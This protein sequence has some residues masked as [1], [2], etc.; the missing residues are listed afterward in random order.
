[1]NPRVLFILVLALLASAGG[2]WWL[3]QESTTHEVDENRV[4]AAKQDQQL[5]TVF[6]CKLDDVSELLIHRAERL[7][8][9]RLVPLGDGL[10]GLTDTIV[11]RASA[12]MLEQVARGLFATPVRPV[13]AAWAQRT[14][15]ELGIADPRVDLELRT[16]AGQVHRLRIG[17]QHPDGQS[18]FAL[19]DGL[20]IQVP[21]YLADLLQRPVAQWRESV[22]AN[23][24]R[25]VTRVEWK[26]ADGSAGFTLQNSG[27]R[28]D[29]VEPIQGPLDPI[30]VKTLLRLINMRAST[31]PVELPD[32]E[33]AN[34]LLGTGGEL[35][36]HARLDAERTDRQV[37]QVHM[38]N[39]V[40]S[41][42]RAFVLPV[43]P[44]DLRLLNLEA[45]ELR[46]RAILRFDPSHISSLR[47][48]RPEGSIE[49]QKG[50]LGWSRMNGEVLPPAARKRLVSHL[51][52]LAN[53][54][55]EVLAERPEDV[56]ARQLMLSIS[57]RPVERGSTLLWFWPQ[58][59]Q[60]TVLGTAE[61]RQH[62]LSELDFDAIWE[63]I[64]GDS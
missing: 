36:L 7:E 20:R 56:P 8:L 15:A 61:S 57:A 1:M 44:N 23:F 43:Y 3:G 47:L 27:R 19:S 49:L 51:V 25:L 30:R 5:E 62:Y 63:E 17:V 64:L 50:S 55:T 40:F 9:L 53:I 14:D 60:G 39:V 37:I 6:P 24:P 32:P 59:D 2:L 33:V 35:V 45:E 22:I 48:T 16:E 4:E 54:E 29:L 13:D 10:W 11:D 21:I 31:L 52:Q 28:W 34:A 38:P 46:S 26:P 58:A 42:D 41:H 18:A 12:A